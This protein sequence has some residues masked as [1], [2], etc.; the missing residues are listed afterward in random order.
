MNNLAVE[1]VWVEFV[2]P[3]AEKPLTTGPGHVQAA[4][5]WPLDSRGDLAKVNIEQQY[6]QIVGSL[7]FHTTPGSL[8]GDLVGT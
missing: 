8:G 1:A 5:H 2:L 7:A 4:P 6:L 3:T